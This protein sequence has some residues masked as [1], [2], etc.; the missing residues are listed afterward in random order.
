[1]SRPINNS[2]WSD[3]VRAIFGIQGGENPAADTSE[4]Q[5]VVVMQSDRPEWGFAGGEEL[6]SGLKFIG[7]G[8]GFLSQIGL[9]NPPDSNYLATVRRIW[10]NPAAVSHIMVV[11]WIDN[12]TVAHTAFTASGFVARDARLG[13]V[14]NFNGVQVVS[15]NNAAPAGEHRDFALFD[16]AVESYTEPIIVSPGQLVVVYP[17]ADNTGARILNQEVFAGID[18]YVKPLFKGLRG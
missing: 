17:V 18:F 14:P 12:A 16:P 6:R 15:K 10:A 13:T 2:S 3:T 8:V 7:A 9:R 1:M 5:P 4:L 11:S